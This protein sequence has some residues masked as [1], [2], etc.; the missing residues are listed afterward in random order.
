MID[1]AQT[2]LAA[3]PESLLGEIADDFLARID[4]GQ[5]PEIEAYARQHPELAAVIREVFPALAAMRECSPASPVG[6]GEAPAPQASH[7]LG[8]YR[9]VRELGR[10]GMGVVYEA[11]QL[12]LGRHVA[13]KVLPFAAALDHKQLQR[14]KNEAQA[15]ANLHHA[16]IVPVHGIGCERGVHYYA[17]QLIEG[18]SLAELIAEMN[19]HQAEGA[20]AKPEVADDL[21]ATCLAGLDAGAS[22]ATVT[23]SLNMAPRT[24][25]AVA[26]TTIKAAL[27]TEHSTK[28]SAWFRTVAQMG[29]QAATALEYAHGLGVIHRDIKPANL[30][31]DARGNLWITDFGLAHVQTDMSLTMTGDLVGT[32]RYMSP[33]QALAKR[34]I[35]DHRT[36]I[37]SLGMTLYELL[38]LTPAFAGRDRH[39]LLRQIAFE[40]PSSPRRLNSSIPAE[41]E[42]IVLKA[43]AKNPAER[44]A[45]AQDL[46][47]DLDR[48]L[49][50]EPIRAKRPTLLGRARKWARRHRPVVVSA[51]VATA[52][53]LVVAILALLISVRNISTALANESQAV[54]REQLLGYFQR[55]ALAERQH[56]AGNVGR[57]EELLSQCP[58]EM[59]GW[60]WHFLK[61]Q[62][63]GNAPPLKHPDTVLRVAFSPDGTQIATGCR[64]GT[65]RIWDTK[66]SSVLH[67]LTY[68]SPIIR[69]LA[70]SPDGRQLAVAHHDGVVRVWK[71]KTGESM[72]TLRGH[73][74]HV[75][76]VA[77]S[78]DGRMLAS[79][80]QDRSVRLWDVG[81]TIDDSQRLVRVLK[82]H[83]VDVKGV[84]FT[85]DG[86]C[87]VA[88]CRDGTVKTWKMSSG[89]EMAT[90][91]RPLQTVDNACFSPDA[92]RLAWSS[93][94][95]MIQVW[96]LA[97]GEEK[98][99]EQSNT[100]FGRSVAFSP[101]GRLIALAGFDG[102]LRLLDSD[103]GQERLTI[104]AHP[105]LVSGVSFSPD[106]CQLASA[107][108]D[109]TVRTWDATP[110]G[111][112]YQVSHCQTLSG[113]TEQVYGVAFSPDSRWLASASLDK[114]VRVWQRRRHGESDGYT[115]RYVLRG[116][117]TNVIAVAF[118]ADGRTLASASWDNTVKL[119]DLNAPQGD[120]LALL[121]TIPSA[122]RISSMDFSPDGRLLAVGQRGGLALYDPA[123]GQLARPF[124]P[125][126]TPVPTLAFR[127]D[128]PH[129]ITSGATD[130]RLMIWSIDEDKPLFF[131][132]H[133]TNPNGS[134]AVSPNG[135]RIATASRDYKA[136]DAAVRVWQIDWDART[137]NDV[138]TLRGHKGYIWRVAFSPDPEGRYLASG[139]WDSTIKIWDLT[140]M[141]AEPVTLRGHAGFIRSLT[142]SPDGQSLA[143][144]SGYAG[145]GEIKIWDSLLWRKEKEQVA[146]SSRRTEPAP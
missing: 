80:S 5:R 96:D 71:A 114:T 27:S 109:Q 52:A 45:T 92:R 140:D 19:R 143:S 117:T 86:Q 69:A 103:N 13:L 2:E 112:D 120:S 8:D 11:E 66:T 123:T 137:Y 20:D 24:A 74:E 43:T 9:I 107:S 73:T 76:Q 124:K 55:I 81:E 130:P 75:W 136:G 1:D 48:F 145:N 93:Q 14:F 29:R 7:P 113:H 28:S 104:Y 94:D 39:E 127:P 30:L 44:Y 67:T 77:F 41:L 38:T 141:S 98:F 85:P 146:A 106:G 70:Y 100:G 18:Q 129:I 110:L 42:T 60:E 89:R 139:S 84:A 4:R 10:G 144:A 118:S 31:I 138:A 59:R 68:E 50:D 61:R 72:A 99:A 101:D 22:E 133:G 115:A 33:E 142:F 95:G 134:V 57:A 111:D 122:E 90:F 34:V 36:D 56:S 102:T 51:A 105:S 82:D 88:A 53:V 6:V 135:K 21:P 25:Q 17:M 35:I 116:H 64:D 121:R 97:T 47:D 91:H 26:A 16:N 32:L 132:R 79:A 125:T 126:A 12:S 40:E 62:R 131:I 37:Y 108:Y 119:W 58:E 54:Q 15:A 87:V 128:G 83:P 78:G 23:Y 63:Y 49:N 65:V 3:S 46:A